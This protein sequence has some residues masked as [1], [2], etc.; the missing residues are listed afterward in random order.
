MSEH[1]ILTPYEVAQPVLMG[2]SPTDFR[3]Q[4]LRGWLFDVIGKE[5]ETLWPERTCSGLTGEWCSDASGFSRYE[6]GIM[7]LSANEIEVINATAANPGTPE[8]L[9]RIH[10]NGGHSV[11]AIGYGV[12]SMGQEFEVDFFQGPAGIQKLPS[13]AGFWVLKGVI[14]GTDQSIPA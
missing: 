10:H 4:L 13:P 14:L 11:E 9:T 5:V 12:R 3:M 1:R 8:P 7:G 6:S 2:D